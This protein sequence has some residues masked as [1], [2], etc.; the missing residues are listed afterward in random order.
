MSNMYVPNNIFLIPV[1]KNITHD[2]NVIGYKSDITPMR[3][4]FF[5]LLYE[6]VY[7]KYFLIC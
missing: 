5:R 1:S 6:V 4:R 2:R 3:S 7:I